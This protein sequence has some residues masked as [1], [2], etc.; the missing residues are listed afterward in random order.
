MIVEKR[1]SFNE[2]L[3]DMLEKSLNS[4]SMNAIRMR[5][6]VEPEHESEISG[7]SGRMGVCP[8]RPSYHN[9]D[10]INRIWEE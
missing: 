9:D 10:I 7:K 2:S 5:Y 4:P 6:V 3:F 8:R 1:N